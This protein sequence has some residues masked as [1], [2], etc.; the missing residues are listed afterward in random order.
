MDQIRNQ[1]ADY[2]QALDAQQTR[3]LQYQQAIQALE[4]A[5]HLCGLPDLAV[6]NIDDYHQ[7]FAV[8]AIN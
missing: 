8:Q 3:N 6:K 2:K 5:K 1:L 7:E 4:K